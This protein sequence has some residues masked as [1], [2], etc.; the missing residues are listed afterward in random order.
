[1]PSAGISRFTDAADD[2]V[3]DASMV[4]A[5]GVTERGVCDRGV[6]EITGEVAADA[7]WLYTRRLLRDGAWC[8]TGGTMPRREGEACEGS[9]VPERD[10]ARED[11]GIVD[12]PERRSEGYGR[13]ETLGCQGMMCR[14]VDGGDAGHTQRARGRRAGVSESKGDREQ[15]RRG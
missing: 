7:L 15:E 5:G 6:G 2:V 4:A 12:T 8:S 9:G 11:M 3:P 13:Q 1:M 14:P 10:G